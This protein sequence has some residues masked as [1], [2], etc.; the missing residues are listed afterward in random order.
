M[1][2][3]ATM[4]PAGDRAGE[5]L[6]SRPRD[7]ASIPSSA[8]RSAPAASTTCSR[9]SST[10]RAIRAGAASRRPSARIPISSAR[11]ASPPC[12]A[13]GRRAAARARQ[14]VRHAQAHDRPRPARER[15]Q[16]RPR[17]HLASARCARISSR[18]S[19][20]SSRAPMSA[21][22]CLPTTR[23]T[24]CRRH[25]N[26]WLL[27]DVL[28]GEWGFKGAVVSDY[29]AIEQLVDAPSR[30][31][32]PRRRGDPRPA[33]RRRHG[34]ARRRRLSR[35]LPHSVRAGTRADGGDRHRGAPHPHA[36]IPGRPVRTSLRRCRRGRRA[37]RQCRGPRAGA[38]G[39]AQAP[40]CCSRTMARCRS[41]PASSGTL[42]VIGP[43][44]A[45]RPSGRLFER[46]APHGRPSSTASRPSSATSVKI[47]YRRGREDHP[48]RRLVR[49]RRRARR[50]GRE[51]E[52][53]ST[54]RS[55]SR[56]HADKIVLVHRRHRADQ[57]RGLGQQ[58]SR[59][60]R[61]PRPRRASRTISPTPSSRSASPSSSC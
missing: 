2:R 28:R 50:S 53:A 14:G 9:P 33:C 21:P 31:A 16:C 4:L 40:S 6:G 7:A 1:R 45:D 13:S 57:P 30:R 15:H 52:A 25:A 18:R 27:H 24:A 51:R 47:V 59:R 23:S 34:P 17:R 11:W 36:E 43:N 29:Y 46:A 12:A 19:R 55:K 61:Q 37:H 32:R 20:K 41:T 22:S 58:S 26:H 56:R 35:R 54:K 44:A 49:R 5:H 39:R 42:A 38:R 3:D 10:W 48:E 8:A 60:P